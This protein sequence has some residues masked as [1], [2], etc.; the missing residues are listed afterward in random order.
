MAK[1]EKKP[2]VE[3]MSQTTMAIIAVAV[4]VIGFGAGYYL[5]PKETAGE[6]VTGTGPTFTLDMAKVND[7]ASLFEDYFYVASEGSQSSNVVYSSYREYSE[8]VEIVYL[9]DGSEFPI[10]I[11]KDYRVLYPSVLDVEEFKQQVDEAKASMAEQVQ[12]PAE[13]QKTE[14]PEVLLFVMSFCP[15][16]NVAEDAMAPVVDVLGET[17]YFEPIYI[18]SRM[19]DGSWASL[20]GQVELNQ[21]I[22]EKIIYELY[23]ADVWMDYVYEV[24]AQCDYVNAD[25]CWK[26]PAEALGINTTA[27][28]EYFNNQTKVDGLLAKE[29]ALTAAYGVSGSPTLIINGK[30]QSVAR[31]PE[32][33]KGAICSA[34]L[35]APEG[36]GDTLSDTQT[37]ASGSCG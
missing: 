21:D 13:L 10:Y 7:I 23:G 35:S 36:C 19:S 27:V 37:A 26:A 20:H 31:T 4:L 34:Y 6:T 17:V 25:E 28:E 33:Y 2:G 12:E 24:N 11:S 32:S 9:I 14:T 8:Y 5:A 3:P 29:A 1:E 22:R 16:G 18:V 15:Y 30:T